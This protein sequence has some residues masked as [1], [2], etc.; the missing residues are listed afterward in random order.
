MGALTSWWKLEIVSGVYILV[1]SANQ[2]LLCNIT[3]ANSIFTVKGLIVNPDPPQV[4]KS[5]TL[6]AFIESSKCHKQWKQNSLLVYFIKLTRRLF[7]YS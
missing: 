4:G 2:A 1:E 6:K 3:G 5:V 7:P